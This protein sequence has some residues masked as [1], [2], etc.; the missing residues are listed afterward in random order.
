[1]VLILSRPHLQRH[2]VKYN[3]ILQ[4]DAYAGYNAHYESGRV[5]EAAY[6]V[7]ARHKNHNVHVRHPTTV[8]TEALS[9]IVALYVI[10]SEIRGSPAEERLTVR[11]LPPMQSLYGWI[12]HQMCILSRHSI[13]RRCSPIY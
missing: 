6:V 12:Q 8:T 1:M 4:A 5:T 3:D 11:S 10:E 2:L 13:Q 9:H 7:Y